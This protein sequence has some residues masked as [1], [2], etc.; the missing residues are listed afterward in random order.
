MLKEVE[1]TKEQYY[2][3]GKASQL[4]GV[5]VQMLRLYE[6]EGLIIPFKKKSLHRLYSSEDIER[7]KC[8]RDM[9]HNEKISI[10]GI[11]R[12]MALIPCWAIKKCPVIIREGC[13]AFK[14]HTKPCWLNKI[15]NELCNSNECRG[16]LV[17]KSIKS[18]SALKQLLNQIDNLVIEG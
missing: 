3:I 6:D 9:I 12:M 2:T 16:C 11:K 10:I 15:D 4:V 5:S 17:Y 8:I 13:E 18:C 7:L 1:H 14:D